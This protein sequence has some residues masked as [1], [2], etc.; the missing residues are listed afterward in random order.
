MRRRTLGPTRF[1]LAELIRNGGD[2]LLMSKYGQICSGGSC[3]PHMDGSLTPLNCVVTD[4]CGQLN[5]GVRL[6]NQERENDET[7]FEG[8]SLKSWEIKH[9]SIRP[10]EV[11]KDCNELACIPAF[12]RLVWR[13]MP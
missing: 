4:D 10:S 7:G 6:E 1:P 9:V 11:D 3:S 5:L 12:E 2:S 8:D 13:L